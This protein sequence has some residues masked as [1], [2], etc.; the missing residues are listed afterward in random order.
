MK[1]EA[2]QKKRIE[3]RASGRKNG[4]YKNKYMILGYCNWIK[5]PRRFFCFIY[6]SENALQTHYFTQTWD[7][8]TR[9]HTQS[10]S[11]LALNNINDKSTHLKRLLM[12]SILFLFTVGILC[13]LH[14]NIRSSG[15]GW[16][17]AIW[18]IIHLPARQTTRSLAFYYIHDLARRVSRTN[19]F[20]YLHS[21]LSAHSYR[22]QR[23]IQ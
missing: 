13:I 6:K 1:K 18:F 17:G 8:S 5:P 7:M 19:T 21:A 15:S 16:A 11:T 20:L 14:I 4:N 22:I 2:A 10:A 3:M 23:M 9:A 12:H